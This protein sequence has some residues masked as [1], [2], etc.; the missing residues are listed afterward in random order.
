MGDFLYLRGTM[1][2]GYKKFTGDID[3]FTPTFDCIVKELG[4][5][6]AVVFGSIY[7]FCQQEDGVCWAAQSKIGDRV[8][9]TRKTVGIMINE[10]VKA[11]YL[12]DETPDRIGMTHIYSDTGKAK[13]KINLGAVTESDKGCNQQL[14]GVSPKVT[15]TCNQRLHKD[16]I[17]ET[18]NETKKK[19]M[20]EYPK[21]KTYDEILQEKAEDYRGILNS[22]FA[23]RMKR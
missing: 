13:I 19:P 17:K 22:K 5:I 14:Q 23:D 11:N 4:L 10:L 16:T 20:Y 2:K 1:S 15:T 18:T 12:K 3:G 6:Q 9:L 7:R 8:G 21:K